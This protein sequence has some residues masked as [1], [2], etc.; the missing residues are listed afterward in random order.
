[1]FANLAQL[2]R[3]KPILKE[4][5]GEPDDDEIPDVECVGAHMAKAAARLTFQPDEE[6][7][8]AYSVR[9][10]AVDVVVETDEE[11]DGEWRVPSFES[12]PECRVTL[13]TDCANQR[14]GDWS[15]LGKRM[16]KGLLLFRTNR[17]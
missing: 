4:L 2:G 3:R 12:S 7:T 1:L 14:R 5:L 8:L 10:H 17:I 15:G 6:Q 11:E 9:E 13:A 16:L